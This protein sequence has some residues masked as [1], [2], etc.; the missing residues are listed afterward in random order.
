MSKLLVVVAGPT[1][2][3]KTA[4]AI[5]LAKKF[6][7][8]I[9]SADSRQFYK[10]LTIGTAKPTHLELGQAKHYFIN[11]HSISEDL[12]AGAYADAALDLLKKLFLTNDIVI[13]AGGSGLY[14]D[15]LIN[16]IDD[17]PETD[18][19]LREE[20]NRIY[21]EEGL[22]KLR[23]LL[24]QSDPDS[25]KNID[26]NNPRRITRALE[27]TIS[28]GTP[29]STLLG[30]KEISF[31]WP[32]LITGIYWEREKLYQ[33]INE[34]VQH[35]IIQGLKEETIA[36]MA[37]RNKNALRTVGYKEMFEHIDGNLSLEETIELIA[38]NTRNYAKRQMTWFKRYKEMLWIHPEDEKSLFETIAQKL[39]DSTK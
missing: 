34:R 7:T 32:W 29:Y 17:L 2:S 5:E 18:P 24:K 35:M 15:A 37:H 39:K 12:N 16:G 27:V 3:G 14:I 30:K 25:L 33:R 36:V 31:P 26:I 10:E 4:L 13:L 21:K 38:K 23:D 22:D 8:V 1:A 9:V 19:V 6:N 28:T 20:L 11:S